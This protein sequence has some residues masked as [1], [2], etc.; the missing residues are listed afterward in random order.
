MAIKWDKLTVKSQEAIAAG[1]SMAAEYGNPE[2]MPLHLLAALLED[3]EGIV[4]PV[5]ER[6]GVPAQQLLSNVNGAIAKLPKI[7]GAQQQPSAGAALNRV[8]EQSFKEADT[9]K[10]EYVSTEHLLLALSQ[11]KTDPTQ[12]AA[13]SA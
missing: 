2:V 13:R 9:F 11:Q 8:L 1:G 12:I 7:Q 5:L 6:I 4:L 3:R 10:D